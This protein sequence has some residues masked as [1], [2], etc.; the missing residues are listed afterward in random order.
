MLVDLLGENVNPFFINQ[1]SKL[2]RHCWRI[3]I[4]VDVSAHGMN[5]AK[6]SGSY[7]F[8]YYY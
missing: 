8:F 5:R 4:T 2:S 1:F 7:L 3:G 6:S